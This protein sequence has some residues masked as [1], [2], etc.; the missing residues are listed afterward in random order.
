[1]FSRILAPRLTALLVASLMALLAGCGAL[2][3]PFQGNSGA[4]AA[5]LSQPPPARL[6]V[7]EPDSAFLAPDAANFFASTLAEAL[8]GQEVP[9]IVGAPHKGDWRVLASAAPQGDMIV[10]RFALEDERGRAQG[11]VDGA[12]IAAA[13]WVTATP[14]LLRT[15]AA[16]AAPKL[17]ALLTQIHAA[18]RQSDP[19]SLLNRPA[20][21]GFLG[22]S[23]AP[24]DGDTALARQIRVELPKL[25]QLIQ[26]K[27][28]DADFTLEGHVATVPLARGQMSVEVQWVINDSHG[29]ERGRVVQL[30]ELTAG[31]LD[32]FWGDIALVVAREA[33]GGIRDVI[34]RQSG[35]AA[36]G[37]APAAPP[38]VKAGS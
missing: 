38:A 27:A 7:P 18:R 13:A 26:D 32:H 12:P 30:N 6:A 21:L 33:A 10:P 19:N 1:M 28:S 14:S 4:T 20:R 22:V 36:P 29:A 35:R 15:A 11:S 17:A 16:E 3:R 23:G 8:A 2:P 37:D 31:T 24:G 25:G 9:A 5:R 34:R